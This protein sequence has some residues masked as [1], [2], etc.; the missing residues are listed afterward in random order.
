MERG[1]GPPPG[2]ANPGD[3]LAS[4][5][6]ETQGA[7]SSMMACSAART[8]QRPEI[9]MQDREADRSMKPLA[10]QRPDHAFGSLAD[11][12]FR[13]QHDRCTMAVD[14]GPRGTLRCRR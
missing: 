1:R 9:S 10:T 7:L 8:H 3:H 4:S 12:A 11:L 13:W 6:N 14:L 5:A 2:R